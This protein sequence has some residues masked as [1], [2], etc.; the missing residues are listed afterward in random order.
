MPI[1]NALLDCLR[2]VE[3]LGDFCVGGIRA[4]FMPTIDVTD[5]LVINALTWKLTDAERA[6]VDRLI[7][8]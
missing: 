2:S 8:T 1:G 6:E 3:R 7:S 4:I 5:Q